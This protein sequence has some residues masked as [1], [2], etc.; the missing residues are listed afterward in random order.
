MNTNIEIIDGFV[1]AVV[2][3]ETAAIEMDPFDYAR[4]DKEGEGFKIAIGIE[5]EL[6]ATWQEAAERNNEKRSFMAWLED[7]AE[8]LIE[9]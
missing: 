2:D 6:L 7:K 9:E 8:S 1:R 4:Q 3:A 5:S